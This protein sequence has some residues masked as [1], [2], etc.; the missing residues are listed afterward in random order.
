MLEVEIKASLGQLKKE[1]LQEA[2]HAMGFV[3]T[4]NLQEVDVYFNGN[5]RNFMK[6]DEA[7]RLRCCR[8]LAAGTSQSLITYKG[9]KLDKESSTRLEYETAIGDLSVMKDLLTALGYQEVFT[10]D[11]TR[12]E[13]KWRPAEGRAEITLCLD[14]VA[15]LG[16]YLE[17]ETLTESE[18]K[19]Q[20]AVEALL[21]LLDSLGLSRDNLTRKSYL[22][23]LIQR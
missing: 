8:D 9:P 18:S 20:G 2:A 19:R 16:D 1:Q 17:L 23:L 11:K 4:D 14:T 5:D 21:Q 3:Q 6:T 22:E 12:Q 10:V 13:W 7:L 15:G